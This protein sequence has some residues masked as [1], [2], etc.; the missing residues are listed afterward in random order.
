[1]FQGLALGI[2]VFW[3]G[4]GIAT[5]PVSERTKRSLCKTFHARNRLCFDD[6]SSSSK[7]WIAFGVIAIPNVFK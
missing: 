4:G 1:M 7:S 3:P 5:F 2:E 6:S